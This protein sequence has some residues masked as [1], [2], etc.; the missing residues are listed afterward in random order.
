M[1]WCQFLRGFV[2]TNLW[3]IMRRVEMPGGFLV[4]PGRDELG[5]LW[6]LYGRGSI[7][8]T[9]MEDRTVRI[10]LV[11]H[12]PSRMNLW[13]LFRPHTLKTRRDVCN[14][15]GWWKINNKYNFKLRLE[16]IHVWEAL[17]GLY[18][19]CL[20]TLV[21]NTDPESSAITRRKEVAE[22]SFIPE[23]KERGGNQD[24]A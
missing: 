2:H 24:S 6:K 20:Q 18:T 23:E 12:W 8:R 14:C 19:T 22:P 3:M 15:C 10:S 16:I 4:W 11:V 13:R 7:I 9:G 17:N 5:L 1:T 21:N